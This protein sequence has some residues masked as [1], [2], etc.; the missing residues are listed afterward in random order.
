MAN[1][2]PVDEARTGL[3]AGNPVMQAGVEIRLDAGGLAA[4]RTD[5]PD[6]PASQSFWLAWSQ[7]HPGTLLWRA[8]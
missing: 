7:F 2:F 1:A 5:G 6:L 3:A 4:R 8:P